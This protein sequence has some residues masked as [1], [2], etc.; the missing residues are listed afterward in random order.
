MDREAGRVQDFL[1][2]IQR[3]IDD[4]VKSKALQ[5]SEIKCVESSKV[6]L[7]SQLQTLEKEL[8]R[9]RE[10]LYGLVYTNAQFHYS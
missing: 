8:F 2:R 9:H 4:V 7:V 5:D 1:F 10:L 3:Q 6:H